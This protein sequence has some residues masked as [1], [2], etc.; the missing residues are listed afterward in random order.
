MMNER[1]LRVLEFN[2]ILE[3]L[4]ACA[5]TDGG[6]AACRE[7]RPMNG[8]KAVQHAQAETEEAVVLLSRLGGF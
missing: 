4:E 7:L 5:V 8:M 2:R 1:A 6:K 3:M